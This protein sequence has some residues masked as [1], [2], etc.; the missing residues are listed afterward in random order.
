M[1]TFLSLNP[2]LILHRLGWIYFVVNLSLSKKKSPCYFFSPFSS[3]IH[4]KPDS[5]Q[6]DCWCTC[7]VECLRGPEPKHSWPSG[8]AQSEYDLFTRQHWWLLTL[9]GGKGH[10]GDWRRTR[11]CWEAQAGAVPEPGG[12]WGSRRAVRSVCGYLTL[13]PNSTY[14]DT[15]DGGL[16]TCLI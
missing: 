14:M 12:Y 9:L 16:K 6:G 15:F 2:L 8:Q 7:V 4:Q 13:K 1:I 10:H 5:R 11:M 3:V